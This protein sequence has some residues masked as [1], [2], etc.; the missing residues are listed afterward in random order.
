MLPQTI[1]FIGRSGSGKGTQVTMLQEFLRNKNSQIQSIHIETGQYF[2]NFIEEKSVSAQFAKGV[3]LEGKRQPDFLA[4]SMWGYVLC[5]DYSG[6][7]HLIFDGAPRS[8]PEAHV[9]EDALSFYQRFD[10]AKF[11]KPK[12]IYIDVSHDW[13][14]ERMHERGRIDDKT[15]EQTEIRM[16]WFET[17]VKGAIRFFE[18]SPNFDFL[19]IQGEKSVE[20]VHAQIISHFV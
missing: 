5:K 8:Y 7:E 19:H 18:E 1:I 12:V 17:E 9:I 4:I 2:R 10:N 6:T 15:K 14:M 11:V 16:N 3:Y 13:S 20:E